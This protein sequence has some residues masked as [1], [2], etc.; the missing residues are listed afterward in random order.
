M[1]QARDFTSFVLKALASFKLR[2]TKVKISSLT[3]K[4]R[5]KQIFAQFWHSTILE[6]FRLL[7]YINTIERKNQKKNKELFQN[8]FAVNKLINWYLTKLLSQSEFKYPI[9]NTF[10]LCMRYFKNSNPKNKQL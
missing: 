4:F 3:T 6:Q 8:T 1:L 9:Q 10:Y 2:R 7:F 5:F